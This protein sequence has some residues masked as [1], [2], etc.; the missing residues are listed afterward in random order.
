[1]TVTTEHDE[2]QTGDQLTPIVINGRRVKVPGKT[3]SYE[4]LVRLAYD[5]A[6]EKTQFEVT[7]RGAK[8]PKPTG[9]LGPGQSVE[10]NAEMVFNVTPADKS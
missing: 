2:E 10:L 5:R 9:M 1:M 4:Q 7:Y 3:I 8:R 6:G